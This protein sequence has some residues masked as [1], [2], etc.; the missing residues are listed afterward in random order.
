M[1]L[2]DSIKTEVLNRLGGRTDLASRSEV[3]INDAYYELLM[4]PRFNFFELDKA[5]TASTAA[6]VRSYDLPT[7]IWYI[8][9]I[10]DNTNNRKLI[11]SH[12]D[13]FDRL[14]R[15]TGQPQRYAR[16]GTTVE[17]DPTPD[18]VYTL[19]VRYKFRPVTLVT[20][21]SPI[22]PREW[23]EIITVMATIKGFEALEQPDKAA[24]QRQLLESLLAIRLDVPQLEDADA[25]SAI[26][27]R[28]E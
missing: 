19:I 4:H 11:R 5:A 28:F 14:S 18:A 1:A 17:F 8:L 15:P 20:G 2:F 13:R 24:L 16:F 23:D 7:D 21:A 6:N 22:V 10:R 9:D 27:P 26:M 12:W 25:E 3:W